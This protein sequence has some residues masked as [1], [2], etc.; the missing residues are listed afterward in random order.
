LDQDNASQEMKAKY[1]LRAAQIQ[2]TEDPAAPGAYKAVAHLKPHFQLE[3]LNVSLR[4]VADLP[5]GAK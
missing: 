2:V 4:L 5:A 3:E 1:P